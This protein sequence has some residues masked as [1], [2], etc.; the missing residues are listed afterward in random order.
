MHPPPGESPFPIKRRV[1]SH[2]SLLSSPAQARPTR[3]VVFLS[4]GRQFPHHEKGL[5]AS[6]AL[7]AESRFI[8][9]TKDLLPMESAALETGSIPLSLRHVETS[10]QG[11]DAWPT[12]AGQHLSPD[13]GSLSRPSAYGK[14][15]TLM[16][17]TPGLH[18]GKGVEACSRRRRGETYFLPQPPQASES[19]V[20]S[21]PSI[22]QPATLGTYTFPLKKCSITRQR[23]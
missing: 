20:H 18:K 2:F 16:P 11:R 8:S 13:R 12:S 21:D 15:A 19:V 4:L 6:L 1:S 17:P 10:D 5:P 22:N 3:H 7:K 9:L 23:R 14:K